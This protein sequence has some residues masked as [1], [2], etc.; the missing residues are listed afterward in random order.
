MITEEVSSHTAAYG[1]AESAVD[2]EQDPSN[3]DIIYYFIFSE[4][5]PQINVRK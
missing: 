5:R 2:R 1:E 3:A 4:I